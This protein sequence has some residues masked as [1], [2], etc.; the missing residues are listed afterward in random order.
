MT[1]RVSGFQCFLTGCKLPSLCGE[2]ARFELVDVDAG[3][4]VWDVWYGEDAGVAGVELVDVGDWDVW[5]ETDAGVVGVE[6]FD[7]ED[8]DVWLKEDA[9]VVV[10][11]SVYGFM[12]SP[13]QL[14]AAS[15]HVRI[16]HNVD[17]KAGAWYRV[18]FRAR[19]LDNPSSFRFS[20]TDS[21]WSAVGEDLKVDTA[22]SLYDFV[23][24]IDD[25]KAFPGYLAFSPTSMEP[26]IISDFTFG[27]ISGPVFGMSMSGPNVDFGCCI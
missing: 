1:V 17:F 3:G 7:V 20:V 4:E 9:G 23:F 27:R 13:L 10:H 2:S 16:V 6:L 8:W 14:G 18:T 11:K 25:F 26:F 12:V 22:G 19:G 21:W 24:R 5:D 15:W